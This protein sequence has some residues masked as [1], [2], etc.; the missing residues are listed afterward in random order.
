MA[1]IQPIARTVDFDRI[2]A[3]PRRTPTLED[4]EVWAEVMAEE[5]RRPGSKAYLLPRQGYALAEIA[6][7]PPGR[8]CLLGLPVGVGKTH[9]TYLALFLWK[10]KAPLFI[11]GAALE[12]KTWAN[13]ARLRPDWGAPPCPLRYLSRE[14]LAREDRE[15]VL[16]SLRPDVIILDEGDELSNW[17]ASAVKRIDRYVMKHPHVRV[18][19]LTGTPG[20]LSV[21]DIWHPLRWTHRED[22]PLPRHRSEAEHWAWAL[23]ER[24]R[25]PRRPHPG[26]L[27]ATRADAIEWVNARITETPGV[28][29]FDG[30]SCDQDI[31]IRQVMA[32]EDPILNE[33][34]R[35]FRREAKNPGGIFV[36]DTLS[37]WLL[38]GQLGCGLY[39]RYVEPPP[40]EWLVARRAFAKF[41]RDRI[42]YS[43]RSSR[44]LDTEAQVVRRH[45]DAPAVTEWQ[46]LRDEFD[47]KMESVWVSTSAVSSAIQWVK[48]ED[49]PGIIWCGSVEYAVALA[50][51]GGYDYFGAGGKSARSGR[52]LEVFDGQTRA[53]ETI[54]ASWN[55]NKRGFNLQAWRRMLLVMP[56]Q[57]AKWLEQVFGRIHRQGQDRPVTIDFLITSGGTLD[58]FEKAFAEAVFGKRTF[59]LTQKILRATIERRRP[60]KTPANQF[61]WATKDKVHDNG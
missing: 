52:G 4:A 38:E 47:P 58:L 17:G 32:A 34:F 6:D 60:R 55:A 28:V 59:T 8:G 33:A 57:S 2:A 56:P 21:L 25:S 40:E 42:M 27:G 46:R 3:L 9:L 11:G 23:D 29:F 61:R 53:T 14:A 1:T 5:L 24:V 18:L 51:A 31:T 36:S 37:A 19:F 43:A 15:H 49:E 20:R 45:P 35:V 12:G 13:F 16:E 50:E 30:D 39:S 41:V 26:P 54:V 10:A 44:P 48:S 22:M 7:A